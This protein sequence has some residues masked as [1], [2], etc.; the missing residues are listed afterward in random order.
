[1][2]AALVASLRAE[3][4]GSQAALARA[5]EELAAARERIA[6]L[7]AGLRQTPRNS[8]R[9]PSSQGLD[10]PPPRRSLRKRSGRKPGGQDGHEGSTLAQVARPD[11]ELRH[12][13]P[14]AAGAERA[15]QP[16]RS[17][18][19]SAARSSTCQRSRSR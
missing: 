15:W 14:A 9:P 10:K 19:W 6:E 2:V 12:E 5:V 17:P 18:G 3:L 8:S 16:G 7:E 11:R 1:M 4:A 13:P